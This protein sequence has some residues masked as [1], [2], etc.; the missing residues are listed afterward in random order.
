MVKI[1]VV[2]MAKRIGKTER[3]EAEEAAEKKGERERA[4]DL[5]LLY[6]TLCRTL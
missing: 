1:D 6:C 4:E 3:R 2:E 5:G